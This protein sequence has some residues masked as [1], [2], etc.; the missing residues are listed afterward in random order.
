MPEITTITPPRVPLV[1]P[2]TGLIA[3]E[4]Y[5][6]FL[7]QFNIA[8]GAPLTR[9]NDT[10][11]TLTLGGSPSTALVNAASLTLGWSGFLA[12][13]RGGTAEDN[14]TGGAANT[15]WARPNGATGAASY[16]AIAAADL[17]SLSST[18]VPIGRLINTTAPLTGGGD[19]SADRTF[20]IPQASGSVDGYLSS[21]DWTTFNNKGS[22]SSVGLS[23]PSIFTVSGSPVT[24]SG[25]LTGTLAN[26]NANIVFAGPSSA[27]AAAPTFRSLV[28]D[29]IPSLAASKITSGLL[30]LAR[31]GT[32]AD[33]SATGGAGQYLKQSSGGAAITVGTIPAS[34]IAS[35]AALTANNDT[36]VT[37]TL[38][39]SPTT[40]LLAAASLTLGWSGT[41]GKARGGTAEDN[42]TGGTANTFWARP[43]GATGAASYRAIVAADIPDLS[44]TY[45]PLD[46]DLT[47]IAALSSADGNFIVGSALGW[48]AESGA[49]ARTSLG[50]GSGDSPTFTGLTLSGLTAT[51]LLA[52]DAGKTLLSVATLT[53]WIA[54]TVNR[55][56]IADDGDGTATLNAPQDL[57][58]LADMQLQSVKLSSGL[59]IRSKTLDSGVS[60]TIPSGYQACVWGDYTINGTL[61]LNG[62]LRVFG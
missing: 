40:A 22:V 29:D 28:A 59:S 13:D 20:A 38:G 6:Y 58:T 62:E 24:T 21:T 19:L 44:G 54:G 5:R 27:P 50:V 2:K 12:K 23:L 47:A 55:V 39:G 56:T 34:D 36:N 52:T 31:G 7:N 43:N 41:L 8:G 42:S 15:F 32:N 14:S 30:A 1:D 46:A 11:V 18:Y 37:L 61:V 45:Q 16:R 48:V 51:R 26:Q 9:V 3:R 57:H 53:N 60:I 10:N 17:P 25:T 4:W 33:L 35:G 49:T